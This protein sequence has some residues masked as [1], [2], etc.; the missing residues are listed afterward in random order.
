VHYVVVLATPYLGIIETWR[1]V[2]KLV[3]QAYSI[4]FRIRGLAQHD[5]K[6]VSKVVWE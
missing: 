2:E 5:G 1:A 6:D 3:V 4:Y